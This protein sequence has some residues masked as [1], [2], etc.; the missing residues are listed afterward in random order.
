MPQIDVFSAG[1]KCCRGGSE[2]RKCSK[3]HFFSAVEVND[4]I[5]T[6]NPSNAKDNF[7]KKHKNTKIFENHLK[8]VMLV[9]IR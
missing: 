3:A 1:M 7:F 9:F 6:L 5:E 2:Q 8:P 4:L